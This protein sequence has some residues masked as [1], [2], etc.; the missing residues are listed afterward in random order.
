MLNREVLKKNVF[1]EMIKY[2]KTNGEDTEYSILLKS[3]DM[4]YII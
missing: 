2:F 3:W 4:T 1:T